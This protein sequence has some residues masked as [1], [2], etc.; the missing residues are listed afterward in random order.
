MVRILVLAVLL[1][2]AEASVPGNS[3]RAS[4]EP[5]RNASSTPE[6]RAP[7]GFLGAELPVLR[8][9]FY[10]LS[11]VCLL[12]VAYCTLRSVR[13]RKP[14]K[15]KKYGLLSNYDDNM[16]MGSVESDE[17]TVFESKMLRR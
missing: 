4:T 12:G 6:A 17:E 5:P 16:E 10:V 9:A 11:G 8:R 7:G 13:L 2:A 3:S 1:G 14:E 15:K